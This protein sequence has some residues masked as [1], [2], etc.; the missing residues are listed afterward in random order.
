LF[1]ALLLLESVLEGQDAGSTLETCH[2]AAEKRIWRGFLR[3][4]EE[5]LI[6]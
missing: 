4:M 2:L 3:A 1:L 6:F 5:S